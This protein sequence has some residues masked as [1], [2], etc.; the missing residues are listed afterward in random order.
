MNKFVIIGS[1]MAG[2]LARKAVADSVP[3]ARV[4]IV[5]TTVPRELSWRSVNG[6]HVLHDNCGLPL[7]EMLVTNLVVLPMIDKPQ[8]LASLSG[9]ERKMANGTYGQ[10]VYGSRKATTSITRMPGV[11]EG[12]DYVQA[13]NQLLREFSDEIKVTKP[14][15]EDYFHKLADT[16]TFVILAIPRYHV[17][18]KWVS[19]P[20]SI[21]FF[22]PAPP[23]GFEDPEMG[24]DN[25]V[26]YNADPAE[27][28]SRTSRVMMG[29]V[30]N[31][32]TEYSKAPQYPVPGLRQ[33][34]KVIDGDEFALPEN[35][36]P[37]GRYG[38]WRS[39]V[40]AHDAYWTVIE[41]M[42]I[43]GLASV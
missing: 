15:Y 32:T 18:P 16:N 41:E 23:I 33:V 2:L 42:R 25:F 4:S 9:W 31:W 38:K 14:V 28:W 6:I 40:L 27:I 35:V 34:E 19:H 3:D 26:V 7:D 1:G 8:M 39:G 29:G 21:V 37:V 13:Y 10:K 24:G 11:I 17:T 22:A 20:F 12:Y 43:R 36:I 30:E 5:T